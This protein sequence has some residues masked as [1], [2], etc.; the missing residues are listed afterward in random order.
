[1]IAYLISKLRV[2]MN[3]IVIKQAGEKAVTHQNVVECLG[4]AFKDIRVTFAFRQRFHQGMQDPAFE[5]VDG[6]GEVEIVEVTQHDN[7]GARV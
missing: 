1:M 5:S 7:L 3:Y 2:D 4:V 6:S